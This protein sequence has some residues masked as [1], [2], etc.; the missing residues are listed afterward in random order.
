[1]YRAGST[2][3][4]DCLLDSKL[5]ALTSSVRYV[6]SYTYEAAYEARSLTPVAGYA[7]GT[8]VFSALVIPQTLAGKYAG[9]VL[10]PNGHV[11]M[12]P[13]NANNIGDFDPATDAFSVVSI[14]GVISHGSK[15]AGGVL[16]PNGHIY[17]VPDNADS[18]GDFD[19]A[20]GSFS[21]LDISGVI[22]HGH[23]YRLGV[24]APNGHIYMVPCNADGIGDFNPATGVFKVI[25]FSSV[26]S[27]A[28]KYY[29]GVLAPN[30]HIYMLPYKEIFHDL[31]Q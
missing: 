28:V 12:V 15:Y 7:V 27:H 2:Q 21:A 26:I 30:G 9:G 11:Y 3:A 8:S 18:I 31:R 22:S 20:T 10:A 19:P 25:G 29:G 13:Y 16:A 14:S 6:S 1:M 24:L 23:K 5:F 17:M 4:A